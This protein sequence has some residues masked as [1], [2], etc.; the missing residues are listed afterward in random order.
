MSISTIA[1]KTDLFE[2]GG[3]SS[4]RVGSGSPSRLATSIYPW[5]S[6]EFEISAQDVVGRFLPST[7][8]PVAAIWMQMQ[9]LGDAVAEKSGVLFP[10]MDWD[11][12]EGDTGALF[13]VTP[14]TADET[15]LGRIVAFAEASRRLVVADDSLDDRRRFRAVLIGLAEESGREWIDSA[16][17]SAP[18]AECSSRGRSR[19]E[20][21]QDRVSAQ[22]RG[23]PPGVERGGRGQRADRAAHG[24]RRDQALATRCR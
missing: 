2:R 23:D 15:I 9:L 24:L 11:L 14:L 3:R 16:P 7:K 20:L 22:H 13:S 17:E 6:L 18:Q 8:F 21:V 4:I 12:D 5:A 19:P 1:T 10:G